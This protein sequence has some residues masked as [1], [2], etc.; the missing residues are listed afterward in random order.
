MVIGTLLILARG[1]VKAGP[2]GKR[3]LVALFLLRTL[4][5]PTLPAS[6]GQILSSQCRLASFPKNENHVTKLM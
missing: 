5:I 1:A 2:F 6:N 4:F 3:S